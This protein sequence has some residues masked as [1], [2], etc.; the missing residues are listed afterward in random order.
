MKLPDLH[1]ALGSKNLSC[2][3]HMILNVRILNKIGNSW[4]NV[5]YVR[6]SRGG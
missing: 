4:K 2:D 5:S 3:H 6:E 1:K